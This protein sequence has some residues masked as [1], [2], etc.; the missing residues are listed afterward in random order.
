[1]SRRV[2]FVRDNLNK[3]SIRSII[4]AYEKHFPDTDY[5]ITDPDSAY[6]FVQ[7]RDILLFSSTTRSI[8]KHILLSEL[9]RARYK[10][11]STVIGGSHANARSGELLNSFDIVA[12]GEGEMIIKDIIISLNNSYN[13]DQKEDTAR[14]INGQP[15]S[16]L[17]DYHIFPK[18]IV[19]LG[20]IELIRGC[21]SRCAFCQTPSIFP[22]KL[23]YRSVGAIAREIEFALSRKG[24]ADIRFI[25]P[26]ASSYYYDN[27][28]NIV[29][30]EELLS[31]V[32]ELVKDRGKIFFGTFPSELDPSGVTEDLVDLLVRYCNNKLIVIGLQSAS[33]RMQKVMTRR[34]G[35]KETE[36]AISLLLNNNFE[37]VIDLIFGLPYED[38][39]SYNETLK[40]IERW[41]G[42]VTI[43]AHPYDPLPG[44]RWE[45]EKPTDIPQNLIRS[46]ASLEGIGKVFG[47]VR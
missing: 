42:K 22:S 37:I 43:H 4:A 8:S 46:V 38:E 20:P 34:S 18:K 2:V 33:E 39:F 26:D 31:T 24:Y 40:F 47:N 7:D 17:D 9:L 45:Y 19:S 32:R 14:I 5:Y 41:K 35:I 3:H 30:I 15:I 29:A 25:A 10:N 28:V 16:N 21:T 13:T 11:I 23:R 6:E 1:M 36:T 12:T 27:G 44:S